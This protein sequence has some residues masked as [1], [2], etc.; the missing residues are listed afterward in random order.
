MSKYH[1][2]CDKSE[3]QLPKRTR[4]GPPLTSKPFCDCRGCS[5]KNCPDILK[6]LSITVTDTTCDFGSK[7]TCRTTK[8][9]SD[10]V[11]TVR[12]SLLNVMNEDR[13]CGCEVVARAV[14]SNIHTN[15]GLTQKR[16]SNVQSE[17]KSQS[18]DNNEK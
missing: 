9:T 16:G 5:C 8:Q 17:S 12:N 15:L 11:E 2:G 3:D 10:Q 1:K 13:D 7:G 4:V 14:R 18:P 6:M